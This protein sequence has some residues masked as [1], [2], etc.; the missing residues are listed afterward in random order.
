MSSSAMLPT[1][2][3]SMLLVSDI[4][5]ILIKLR[6]QCYQTIFPSLSR[7]AVAVLQARERRS[8]ILPF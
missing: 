7:L 6:L 1:F 5:S 4:P 2:H 8:S 3:W